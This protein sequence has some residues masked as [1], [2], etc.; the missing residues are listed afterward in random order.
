MR[1]RQDRTKENSGSSS[2]LSLDQ[3]KD[4]WSLFLLFFSC[5]FPCIHFIHF[6]FLPSW[7]NRI[8][9]RKEKKEWIEPFKCS[10]KAFSSIY[11]L[12]SIRNVQWFLLMTKITMNWTYLVLTSRSVSI[13]RCPLFACLQFSKQR[14]QKATVS[15]LVRTLLSLV[16]EH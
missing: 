7:K 2:S 3:N 15:C 8:E 1:E 16:W 4:R 12:F 14:Q 6:F 13:L 9:I 11:S 5:F 10:H